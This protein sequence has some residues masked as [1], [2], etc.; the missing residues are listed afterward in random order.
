LEPL[1]RLID[2]AIALTF[3]TFSR[4]PDLPRCLP[5]PNRFT[6]F[7]L[8]LSRYSIMMQQAQKNPTHHYLNLHTTPLSRGKNGDFVAPYLSLSLSVLSRWQLEYKKWNTNYSI[9]CLVCIEI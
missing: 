3:Y 7:A 6:G 5:F 4:Y 8:E 1:T 9:F 2:V